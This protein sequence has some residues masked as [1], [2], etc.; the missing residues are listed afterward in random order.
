VTL[1]SYYDEKKLANISILEKK[2]RLNVSKIVRCLNYDMGFLIYPNAQ[3]ITLVAENGVILSKVKALYAVLELLNLDA[4]DKKKKVFLPTWAPDIRHFENL[5]IERGKYSDFTVEKLKEYALIATVDGNFSFTEFSYTRDAIYAS[6]K[7]MELLSIYKIKLSILSASLENFYYK[8]FKID[9]PQKLKGKMM[10]K[11]LQYA[12]GKKSCSRVG[13]KI[14]ED[15]NDWI[16]MIPDQ[17][18]EHLNLYIQ[19]VDDEK[20]E[21]LYKTYLQKIEDFSAE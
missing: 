11:F 17:Y 1:N 14:W 15:K 19:A 10:R 6:L 9:C 8:Q 2:S 12:K 5:I 21:L 3:Q 7:I 13:V 20:G 16:L 4:V 18:S